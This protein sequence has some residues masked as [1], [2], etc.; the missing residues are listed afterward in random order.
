[1]RESEAGKEKNIMIRDGI[2][3][4]NKPAGYT[5]H[6]CVAVIR[7]L[8]GI[9]RVGHTGTLDPHATGVLPVCLG[10]A[11]RIT[12]YLDFDFKTYRCEIEFGKI[13]DTYDI[14]GTLQPLTEMQSRAASSLTEQAIRDALATF[15]GRI[16]QI[17]PKY[18]A[19][20][21]NGKKLYEY[22]RSGQSV[23]IK[24]REIDVEEL[25][26]DRIDADGKKAEFTVKCSKGTYIRSIC[27][28]AGQILG[29]GAVMSGLVRLESG[30]CKIED[31]VTLD[32]LAKMD[33]INK[34]IKSAD[35][36][37]VNLGKITVPAHRAGW[38]INGG[39]LRSEEA[40]VISEPLILEQKHL[41]C[42]YCEEEFLGV[43]VK[44]NGNYKPDKIFWNKKDS[45]TRDE[46]I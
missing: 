45:N 4:L 15:R 17:P 16:T 10:S 35:F 37:L 26:I 8:T 20:K 1:M 34:V 32:E 31:S 30:A 40:Q 18:S 42:V 38:F 5:S 7:R 25:T 41:Y 2:I 19:L 13:S 21:V 33:D 23:E 39:V 36:A 3:I 12:E 46:N 27:H 9:K 14:W 24:S 44:N 22:A 43:A 6:D 29:C 11:A 28:D